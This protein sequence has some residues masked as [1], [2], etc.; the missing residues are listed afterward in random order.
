MTTYEKASACD[1]EPIYN[2]CKQ[3]IDDYENTDSID[4]GKVLNW[5][6]RKIEKSIDEYT[7]VF[8]SG[9]K[10]GYYHFY[11]NEAGEYEIDDLYIFPQYRNQGIGSGIIKKCCSAVSAPVTLYVFSKNKKAVALYKK[12]GFEV[13]RTVNSSRYFMIKKN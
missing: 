13:V 9:E 10:A 7:A 6:R 1:I 5:V 3:L 12:L 2:L 4:Y 11:Q 8:A